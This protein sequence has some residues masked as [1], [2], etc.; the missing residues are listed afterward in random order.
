MII[1]V[2]SQ[3]E[4]VVL[5]SKHQSFLPMTNPSL[6]LNRA[7]HGVRTYCVSAVV[8]CCIIFQE[9]SLQGKYTWEKEQIEENF[10][11]YESCL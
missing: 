11:Q 3:E 8:V 9:G 1:Y 6:S 10:L 2:I 5:I 7:P 4:S